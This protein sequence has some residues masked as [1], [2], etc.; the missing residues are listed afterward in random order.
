MKK[1]LIFS[2]IDHVFLSN[3]ETLKVLDQ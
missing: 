3:Q 2:E 1:E